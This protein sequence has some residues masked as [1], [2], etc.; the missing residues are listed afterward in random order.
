[1]TRRLV[2]L[3][4]SI[5]AV[6][7]SFCVTSARSIDR[8][9]DR[10]A[11]RNRLFRRAMLVWAAALIT[12]V[13]WVVFTNPPDIPGGTVGAL[14]AVIGVLTSVIGFYQWSRAAEDARA[15]SDKDVPPP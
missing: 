10:Q 15:K 6:L 11:N 9:F 8:W 13:I 7:G 5:I 1:M 2:A 12:W 3:A 4:I 14:T